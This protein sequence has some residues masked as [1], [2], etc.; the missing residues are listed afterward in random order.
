MKGRT[1]IFSALSAAVVMIGMF[2]AGSANAEDVTI[3]FMSYSQERLQFYKDAAAEFKKEFPNITVVPETLVEDD[4]YQALPLSFRSK[5]SPDIFVYTRPTAGDYFEL[6]D[7]LENGWAAPL[8]PSALP[9]DFAS[10][11]IGTGNM[12]EPTYSRDG[13]I[14][15]IPR[16]PSTNVLGHGYLFYNK[17]VVETAGLSKNLPQSWDDFTAACEK[18]KSMGKYCL[19]V[20]TQGAQEIERLLTT[21]MGVNV[22]DFRM[23]GPSILKGDY[24]QV[25][26]PDYVEALK[27]LRSLYEK[28]YVVPGSYDKV[29]ARQAIANGDA[30]FY[31]DGG[32]MPSVFSE[33]FQFTNFGAALPPGKNGAGPGKYAGLIGQGPP[34][35]ETFISAQS[36]HIKEAT[37]FLEWMTRPDGWYSKEFSKRGFDA[38]PWLDP[39]QVAEWVPATNPAH[40]LF[41]LDP[42]VHVV[43][44]QASLKCPDLAKSKALTNVDNIR[45][46]WT[47]SA[48]VDYLLNGGDWPAMA[49]PIV[50]EQNRVLKET[51]DAEAATGLKVS[52]Q[53]F[54][55]PNWDGLTPFNNG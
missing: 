40:D 11:F 38:L 49:K 44:P 31:I 12:K 52:Q 14:Y 15:T 50:D 48:I 9:A 34:M 26:E 46:N 3:R 24:S 37:E 10:R 4:Y 45:P 30:A 28:E 20:P 8:D 2:G 6:I 7:V 55:E 53:C 25:L 41:A 47:D 33:V 18:L 17:D 54:A 35:P 43:A 42:Q 36:P 39:K 19:A 29:A 22:K 5:N 13:K 32:W 23:I 27:Y 1:R 21:F 51:L 16:P